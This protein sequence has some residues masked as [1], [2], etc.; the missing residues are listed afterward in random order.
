MNYIITLPS[1]AGTVTFSDSGTYFAQTFN[2]FNQYNYTGPNIQSKEQ[3][4]DLKTRILTSFKNLSSDARTQLIVLMEI[5][6]FEFAFNPDHKKRV[7]FPYF[8]HIPNISIENLR[9]VHADALVDR[10][11]I[12]Y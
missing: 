12:P 8:Q 10:E 11:F 4:I 3:E 7:N 5:D 1:T 2:S 9:R 6:N